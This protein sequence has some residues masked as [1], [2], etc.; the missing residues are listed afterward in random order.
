MVFTDPAGTSTGTSATTRGNVSEGAFDRAFSGATSRAPSKDSGI[1]DRVNRALTSIDMRRL[2]EH[3]IHLARAEIRKSPEG[4]MIDIKPEQDLSTSLPN[5]TIP[6]NVGAEG[7]GRSILQHDY[8]VINHAPRDLSGQKG[9]KAVEKALR[10]RPTPGASKTATPE[11]TRNDVGNLA[12]LDGDD[13]F[14]RSFVV[15]SKDPNRSDIV[16]NYTIDGEH[17]LEE[18]F[19]MRYAELDKDGRVTL[20]T[21]GEGNA[22]PQVEAL[23]SLVWGGAVEKIWGDNAKM[24]FDQ[25]RAS[26]K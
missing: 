20:V 4:V 5:I 6:N 13:N 24:I 2:G 16:V 17:I 7:F 21:Y 14:V 22:L 8:I 12:P 3:S 23:E 19:V 18:G 15:D 1:E 10:D 11:G 9:L 26:L 25:A